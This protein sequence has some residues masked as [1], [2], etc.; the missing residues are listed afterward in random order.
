[1]K[2]NR[3]SRELFIEF[4]LWYFDGLVEKQWWMI[5]LCQVCYAAI[6]ISNKQGSIENSENFFDLLNI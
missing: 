4:S 5:E 2:M 6:Y 3:K 1:M